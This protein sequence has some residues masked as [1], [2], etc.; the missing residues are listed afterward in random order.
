MSKEDT[1]KKIVDYLIKYHPKRIGVFGSFARGDATDKSDIDI[2]IDIEKRI[3]LFDL[4]EM[5]DELSKLLNRKV[6]LI[7]ERSLNENLKKY[8]YDDCEYIYK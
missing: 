6:D 1:Y 5:R 3:N 8:I 4:V 7:T 2:L